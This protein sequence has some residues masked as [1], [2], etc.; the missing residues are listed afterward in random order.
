MGIKHYLQHILHCYIHLEVLLA[1][2]LQSVV[3]EAIV[4]GGCKQVA[5]KT[6][7]LPDRVAYLC[8][9]INWEAEAGG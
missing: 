1:V 9:P 3:V 7:A 6:E 2:C 5:D 4:V 8:N